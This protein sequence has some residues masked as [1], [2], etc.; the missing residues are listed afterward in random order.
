MRTRSETHQQE[1]HILIVT[2][3]PNVHRP[4]E[5]EDVAI[6]P[7]LVNRRIGLADDGKRHI[8]RHLVGLADQDHHVIRL[9]RFRGE[10]R[11]GEII[12]AG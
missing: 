1:R 6:L 7:P 8:A 12:V 10:T 11:I 5:P 9:A 4:V 3:R 2:D